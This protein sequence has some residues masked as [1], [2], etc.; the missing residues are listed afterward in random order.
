MPR[1]RVMDH[2]FARLLLLLGLALPV[3]ALADA[4]LTSRDDF[5]AMVSGKELT[6]P[7]FGVSIKVDPSGGIE[8][9]AMGWPVTGNWR[10][11]N[12]LFCRTMDW[13]GTEIPPNCQLV[14]VV[15]KDRLRFTSDA[16]QGMTAVF[17]LR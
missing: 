8:G 2:L 16:G 11:E 5:V 13:S 14:Q 7:L 1:N 10:W 6:L 17:H 4:P 3:P 15:A 12:G 9:S